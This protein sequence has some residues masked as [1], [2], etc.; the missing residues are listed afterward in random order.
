MSESRTPDQL[1]FER[2]RLAV[3]TSLRRVDQRL[4]R[5]QFEFQKSQSA[6][7]GWKSLVTPTGGLLVAAALG[8]GGT[9]VGKWADNEIENQKQQTTIILKASEVPPGVADEKVQ[10]VQ[11]ARNLL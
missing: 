10:E 2:Q 11:R 1:Q 5:D 4:A 9:A 3:E 6:S 8:L 7:T